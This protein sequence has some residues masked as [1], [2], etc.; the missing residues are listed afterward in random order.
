MGRYERNILINKIG[1]AGQKKISAAR[2]LVCGAGGLGST[3][4]ANLASLGVGH[5]GIVDDDIVELSNLN[6]Q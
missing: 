4:I 6:R 5:I 3:V 2:V 1:D